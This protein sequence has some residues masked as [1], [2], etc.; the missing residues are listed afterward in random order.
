MT[1]NRTGTGNDIL[2]AGFTV[3]GSGQKNLLFR[4]VGPALAGFGV[5][6]PLADPKLEIYTSSGTRIAENDTWSANLADTFGTVGAFALTPGSRDAALTI[7]LP[8]GGYTV[9]VSGADGGTGEALV[10]VYE[11]P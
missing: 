1:R 10:E 11:L 7:M 9:Q 2:I 3:E 5:P 4:A 6:G 8:A